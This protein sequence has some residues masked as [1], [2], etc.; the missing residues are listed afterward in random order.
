MVDGHEKD[1]TRYYYDAWGLLGLSGASEL[2]DEGV[3]MV[4]WLIVAHDYLILRPTKK[5][6]KSEPGSDITVT[7]VL[8]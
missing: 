7:A 5:E 6:R 2:D 3:K 4:T 8:Q 1:S